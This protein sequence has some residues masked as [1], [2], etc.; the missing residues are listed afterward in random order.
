MVAIS[1][2]RGILEMKIIYKYKYMGSRKGLTKL[3]EDVFD[4]VVQYTQKT[5]VEYQFFIEGIWCQM[6]N[7]NGLFYIYLLKWVKRNIK[8][9]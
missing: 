2:E 7:Y 5:L 9:L 4:F 1:G 8:L 6:I 3:K